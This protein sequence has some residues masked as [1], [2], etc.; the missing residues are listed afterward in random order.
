MEVGVD[1]AMN[2]CNRRDL[3]LSLKFRYGSGMDMFAQE[4]PAR[5][6]SEL[7]GNWPSLTAGG[8]R[9]LLQARDKIIHQM[10]ILIKMK[11][12]WLDG[13]ILPAL[14]RDIRLYFRPGGSGELLEFDTNWTLSTL[15]VLGLTN[16][17]MITG[18][19]Y[20]LHI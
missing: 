2:A 8:C 6:F 15:G 18:P 1:I 20:N 3:I 5:L 19:F 13:Y 16:Q 14:G 17:E 12:D 4:I 10:E 9:F 11:F 7:I